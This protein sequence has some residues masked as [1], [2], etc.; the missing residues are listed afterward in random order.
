MCDD[1]MLMC[2]DVFLCVLED[3]GVMVCSVVCLCMALFSR[4]F[5]FFFI[6][7]CPGVQSGVHSCSCMC[8]FVYQGGNHRSRSCDI[9]DETVNGVVGVARSAGVW[10]LG[11]RSQDL[12]HKAGQ[13]S[14][15]HGGVARACVHHV[16]RWG[17]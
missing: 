4:S 12:G 5:V 13:C 15:S 14:C 9:T 3:C 1:V 2:A 11:L 6:H 16:G 17:L 7:V 8:D 10:G